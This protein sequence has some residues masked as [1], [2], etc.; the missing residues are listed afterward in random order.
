ME[1]WCLGKNWNVIYFY[2]ESNIFDILKKICFYFKKDIDM[3]FY[4]VFFVDL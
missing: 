1:D 3:K 4:D 2:F